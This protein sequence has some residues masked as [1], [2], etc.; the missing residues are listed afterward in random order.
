MDAPFINVRVDPPPLPAH[1]PLK[2]KPVDLQPFKGELTEWRAFW[3]VFEAGVHN[4]E[5]LTLV[6]KFTMLRQYLAG[7]TLLTIKGL[8]ITPANYQVARDRLEARYNDDNA[9][10]LAHL[11]ELDNLPAVKNPSNI[12]ALRKFQLTVQLHISSLT[13]LGVASAGNGTLLTTRLLQKIPE[14]LAMK[15]FEDP[16]HTSTQLTPFMVF[17]TNKVEAQERLVA[18]NCSKIPRSRRLS[19]QSTGL[20]RS[21]HFYLFCSSYYG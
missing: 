20:I 17:L 4:Q 9:I 18:S 7:D 14:E 11:A 2:L 19:I 1:R 15:W 5:Q 21:Q 10:I 6:E 13:A 3:S 16:T 12:A 8:D